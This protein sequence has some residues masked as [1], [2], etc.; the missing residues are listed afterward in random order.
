MRFLPLILSVPLMAAAEGLYFDG[1][2]V[3]KLDWNTTALRSAD[4]NGDGLPDLALINR[5]R[6]RIEFL[7]QRKDGPKAGEPERT[8]REDRW[9]PVLELSRL[10]KKPLVIGRRAHALA[11]GDW[12]GDGRPD[13][14][15][16]TDEKKLFLRIQ[17]AAGDWT[18]NTEFTL[19]SVSEDPESL[20]AADL[21]GDGRTDLALL[22]ETRLHVWLQ[23]ASGAWS[24]GKTYALGQNGCG[25]L[26]QADL[27]GDGLTDLCYTSPDADAVFVRLQ[28]KG[29]VFGQEW[30]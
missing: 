28:Q 7:F 13:I 2:E 10:D 23:S 27:D 14:A 25:G 16:T 8:S 6:A 30:R 3:V 9:N 24:D 11:V 1:P 19:D 12:N 20:H 22:T 21:N 18:S 17:A 29:C 26:R 15:F 5:D 4:F